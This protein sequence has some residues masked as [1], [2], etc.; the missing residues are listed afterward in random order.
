L[1]EKRLED[2]NLSDAP[3]GSA[4]KPPVKVAV[5]A[6]LETMDQAGNF[7]ETWDWGTNDRNLITSYLKDLVDMKYISEYVVIPDNS[8]HGM[9]DITYLLGEAKKQNADA[10]LTIRGVM[11]VNKYINP[12]AILDLTILGACLF[13][14]SNREA[15]LLV[16]LNLW[17]VKDNGC[18]MT[19]KGEGEKMI[20]EPTFLIDTRDAVDAARTDTLRKV[21]SEFKKRCRESRF[22]SK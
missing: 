15:I 16:N 8:D 17:N 4:L 5:F 19:V 3:V 13:P 6:D 10:L 2:I 14:G 12:A 1:A 9:Q 11:K 21:L 7:S 18:V 22:N 20:S